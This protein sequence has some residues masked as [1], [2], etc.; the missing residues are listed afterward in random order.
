[1]IVL[2]DTSVLVSGMVSDHVHH[3]Q[4]Q[5]W[6]AKAKGDAFEAVVSGHSLAELYAERLQPL[7]R[8]DLFHL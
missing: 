6:L 5:A 8:Q 1:M 4:T 2:L 3:A 7:S